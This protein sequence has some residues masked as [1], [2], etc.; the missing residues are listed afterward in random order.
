MKE[1][2]ITINLPKTNSESYITISGLTKENIEILLA[3]LYEQKRLRESEMQEG[4]L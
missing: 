4:R 1:E 2:A 3:A